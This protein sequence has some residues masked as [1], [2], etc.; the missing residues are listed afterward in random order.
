MLKLFIFDTQLA[1]YSDIAG[2]IS[3]EEYDSAVWVER[4]RM[5]GEFK[6]KAPLSS[7]LR[8]KM[9]LDGLISHVDTKE[10]MVVENHRIIEDKQSEPTIE[11]SGRS[12]DAFLE[13]RII[14]WNEALIT[15]DRAELTIVNDDTHAQVETL[16]N[17][18]VGS[19]DN[20]I[21]GLVADN[22][23]VA[24]ESATDVTRPL[25]RVN[26][27][28]TVMDILA[29]D[30]YGIR[31]NRPTV[32][33]DRTYPLLEIHGGVDVS[34]EVIFSWDTGDLTGA[35][36][37]WST[38]TR[39][40][41]ALV[42]SRF[43]VVDVPGAAT[44]FGRRTML[45]DAQDLDDHYSDAPTGGTKTTITG[46]M[47]TRG[48]EALANQ[49]DTAIARVDVSPNASPAYRSD[50]NIGDLVTVEGNFETLTTMRVIE[51]IEV[52]DETGSSSTPVLSLY[53]GA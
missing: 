4:Y 30:D 25:R 19:T 43:F 49:N 17:A 23:P 51:H 5:P 41:A 32:S 2:G 11:V 15:D 42:L 38:K 27:H 28:S 7:G 16:I 31:S 22:T 24:G 35:E 36:Y 13:H 10:L 3:I 14:G 44:D 48:Q 12:L 52:V 6:V 34:G 26:L 37:L 21:V 20:D 8:E 53:Q 18:V 9:P 29:V 39:K 45:V 46:L 50:Y 40:N 47:T 33:T 1:D